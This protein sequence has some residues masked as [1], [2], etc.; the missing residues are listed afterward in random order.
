MSRGKYNVVSIN[1]LKNIDLIQKIVPS[2]NA[3]PF[4]REHRALQ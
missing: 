2:Q 4:T 1:Q 3:E